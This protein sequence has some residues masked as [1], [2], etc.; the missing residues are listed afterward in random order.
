MRSVLAL[1]F[2]LVLGL[3]PA[4]ARGEGITVLL[5]GDTGGFD[6]HG[7]NASALEGARRAA[8]QR[9]VTLVTVTA[10]DPGYGPNELFG[11]MEAAIHRVEPDVVI[12][13]GFTFGDILP[14]LA[15]RHPGRLFA[16]VDV[17]DFWGAPNVRGIVFAVD[18]VS[19]AAGYLAAGMAAILDPGGAAVQQFGGFPIPP[20]AEFMVGFAS[21]LALYNEEH[22]PGA[23]LLE[24]PRY[25]CGFGPLDGVGPTLAGLGGG[26]DVIFPVAGAAVFGAI[27][28]VLADERGAALIGVDVDPTL[29]P[30][31]SDDA[32][33]L[34]LTS[35]LKKVDV[36]VEEAILDAADGR[37]WDDWQG[38]LANESVGLA[39]YGAFE[40]RVPDWLRSEVDALLAGGVDTGWPAPVPDPTACDP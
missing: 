6:D 7:F 34:F 35:V 4:D 30:F 32:K 21:G 25:T 16:I 13:V 2:L 37:P 39:P 8:A 9:D 10:G 12:F 36:G 5:V 22:P 26:A 40:E 14:R 28:T 29:L 38:T 23:A 17:P 15:G 20:V 18:E 31:L 24:E 19:L 33:A 27:D 1:A 11:R 3:D